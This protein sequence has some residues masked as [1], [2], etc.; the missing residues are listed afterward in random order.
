[1]KSTNKKEKIQKSLCRSSQGISVM[2]MAIVAVLEVFM[3]GYSII[4]S[5]FYDVYVWRYRAFYI[6]LLTVAIAYII[7]VLYVRKDVERKFSVMN[8]A[9]PISAA[10]FFFWSLLVMYSDYKVTGAIDLTVL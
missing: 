8:I 1:M 10:L 4:N 2:A 9:N 6:S 3:L 7:V 5:A